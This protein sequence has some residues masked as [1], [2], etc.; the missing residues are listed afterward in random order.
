ME[1]SLKALLEYKQQRI[2]KVHNL[3][4]LLHAIRRLGVE[5]QVDE[6]V[7]DQINQ[8][9][10]ETRYPADFGLLP[11]GVPTV[12]IVKRFYRFAAGLLEFAEKLIRQSSN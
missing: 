3:L 4:L 11:G 5:A 12:D 7:L 10:V 2:P 9:Y 8:L 6:D 1:K